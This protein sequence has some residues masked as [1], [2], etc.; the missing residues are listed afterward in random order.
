MW[1]KTGC[2]DKLSGGGEMQGNFIAKLFQCSPVPWSE[3]T[4]SLL[5]GSFPLQEM[6]LSL[7]GIQE[8]ASAFTCALYTAV[9]AANS[10]VES[11]SQQH[12]LVLS[13]VSSLCN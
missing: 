5:V 10:S 4:I 11:S 12:A 9:C 8:R 6:P 13:A 7:H 3:S 1:P 2:R